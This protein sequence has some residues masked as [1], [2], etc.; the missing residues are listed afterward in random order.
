M[1]STHLYLGFVLATLIILA[2]PGPN[3]LLILTRSTTAG[4][5][6]GLA[7]VAG[8]VAAQILQILLVVLGLSWLVKL[9]PITFEIIQFGGAAYL[10]YLGISH[11]IYAGHA[12]N[13]LIKNYNHFR[14]GFFV[15]VSNPKSLMFMAA[16]FPQFIDDA[17]MADQQLAILG[18]TYISLA[19]VLDSFL[20]VVLGRQHRRLQHSCTTPVIKRL[21][22][23]ILIGAGFLLI[24]FQ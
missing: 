1:M 18:G 2:L 8:T 23:L 6:A 20:A 24:F 12:N 5:H 22:S 17:Q 14:S 15:G 7:T 4:T 9:Y 10:I 21:S 16:F 13:Q 19:V 3:L 11:W